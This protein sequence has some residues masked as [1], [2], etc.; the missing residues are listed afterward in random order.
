MNKLQAWL[1]ATRPRT[2]TATATPVLVGAALTWHH[3]GAVD[4]TLVLC[5]V[6]CTLSLQ[7]ATN[8]VNDVSDFQKGT[9]TA[10]RLGPRRATAQGWLSP[11]SVWA[12]AIVA[13]LVAVVAGWPLIQAGGWPLALLG[14]ASLIAAVA[15]TAGPF[16]LAYLGLGELFVLIFF[17]WVAVGGFVF[18]LTLRWDVPGQWLAATQVGALSVVMIAVNNLRDMDGDRRS[19]KRTLAAR[20]GRSLMLVLIAAA[21]FGPYVLGGF[22]LQLAPAAAM[23]P[24][25]ALPVGV[26]FFH[27]LCRTPASPAMNALLGKASLHLLLFGVLLSV[28]LAWP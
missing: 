22:W 3:A 10:E 20:Y 23:L 24:V 6:L 2:L 4:L 26:K 12:G 13:L 25:L 21:T 18:A 15:Y 7:I 11:A 17:G 1:L 8:L 27:A 5:A 19:G 14:L 16:P 28:G 9:D